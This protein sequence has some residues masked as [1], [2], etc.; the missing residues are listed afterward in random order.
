M[1]DM[2]RK[3]ASMG[4]QHTFSAHPVC[5]LSHL[6]GAEMV[7]ARLFGAVGVIQDYSIKSHLVMAKS[8]PSFFK[9]RRCIRTVEDS[10]TVGFNRI[11][12]RSHTRRMVGGKGDHRIQASHKGF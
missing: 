4:A 6:M 5:V 3:N 2:C 11:E 9:Q 1:S 12:H 10:A 8:L 7:S